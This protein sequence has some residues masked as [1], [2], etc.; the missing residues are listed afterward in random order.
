MPKI[1]RTPGTKSAGRGTCP[2]CSK[3]VRLVAGFGGVK[4]ID[5]HRA[6]S[7]QGGCYGVGLAPAGK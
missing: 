1:R 7:V 4:V 5:H 6:E 2:S 3:S